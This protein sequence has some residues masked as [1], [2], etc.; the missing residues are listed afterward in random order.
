MTTTSTSYVSSR[1]RR[2]RIQIDE[3]C[4]RLEAIYRAWTDVDVDVE[5][6]GGGGGGGGGGLRWVVGP[7]LCE[8]ITHVREG[9]MEIYPPS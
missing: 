5:H 7:V 4:G 3:V 9:W 1:T 8:Y 6:P 2:V